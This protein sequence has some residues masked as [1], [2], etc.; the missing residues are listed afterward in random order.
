MVRNEKVKKKE[1]EIKFIFIQHENVQRILIKKKAK[2][3]QRFV[4][5]QFMI[6]ESFFE[7]QLV[8][9]QGLEN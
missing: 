2:K 8:R 3:A 5:V 4:V 9:G 6:V 7:W 1:N